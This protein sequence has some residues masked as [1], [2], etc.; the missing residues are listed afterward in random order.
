M[1]DLKIPEDLEESYRL[2]LGCLAHRECERCKE[3]V[4]YIE[5][6]ARAEQE[7][8]ALKEALRF[9]VDAMDIGEGTKAPYIEALIRE[10]AA[11]LA[12]PEQS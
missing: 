2:M 11:R 10:A 12:P 7:N 6:I 5:R 3:G 9:H 4:A 1:V 8:A